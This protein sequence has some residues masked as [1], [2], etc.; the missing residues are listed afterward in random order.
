MTVEL[1]LPGRP[2]GALAL[3]GAAVFVAPSGATLGLEL[4]NP[5][6]TLL[7]A[8]TGEVTLSQGST[9]LFSQSIE[10]AAFVPRTQI[11]L[12]VPWPGVPVEGTYIAK[13][14]LRP[15]GGTPIVFQRSVRFG[16]GAIR[17]YREQTG[18]PATSAAGAP[19]VLVV[20]PGIECVVDCEY[21][22]IPGHLCSCLKANI[23]FFRDV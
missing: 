6:N 19:V 7:T 5:G 8:T 15:A 13:G 16:G 21:V 20:V 1:R 3:H 12:H 4:A 9:A 23:S 22:L 2:T 18:K 17:R 14:V 11:T 10:L